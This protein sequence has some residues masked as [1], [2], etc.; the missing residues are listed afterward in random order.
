MC[1]SETGNAVTH[2]W[3]LSVNKW[4]DVK[5][6]DM[7]W[8]DVKWSE[9]KWSDVM[10]SEVMWCDVKWSE[11][12]WGEVKWCEVKWSDVKWSDVK[13][14][15]VKWC[16]VKWCEVKWCGVKWCGVNWRDLCEVILFWSYFVLK[17]SEV[18]YGEVLGDKST[19]YIMMTLYWG[20]L[21]VHK[22]GLTY[23]EIIFSTFSNQ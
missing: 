1:D 16:E 17:W 19:L 6:S 11:V 5:W 4:R 2:N 20:Y 7:K 14:S 22:N 8:S 10:W 18:S 21:S 3:G 15:E 23:K 12:M 9:L 13:W